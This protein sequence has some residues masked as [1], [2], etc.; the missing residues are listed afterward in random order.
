MSDGLLDLVD[1]K[2]RVIG[3]KAAKSMTPL[4]MGAIQK[5]WSQNSGRRNLVGK[6]SDYL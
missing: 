4:N 1:D 2:D 3:G 6:S 5:I